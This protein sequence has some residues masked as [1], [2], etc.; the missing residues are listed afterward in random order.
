MNF[1]IV[2]LLS[3]YL[4]VLLGQAGLFLTEELSSPYLLFAALATLLGARR[5]LKGAREVLP[6]WIANIAILLVLALSLFSIFY[7]QAL[8]LQ[9]LV[10]FL[11]ALQAVKLVAAK[12]GRDWL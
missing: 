12:K 4:L 6:S 5:E 10:H 9:E 11:L 8:P 2:F 1:H 7:L 3:S